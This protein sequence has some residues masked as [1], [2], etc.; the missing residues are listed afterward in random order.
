[1]PFGRRRI[2]AH[3]ADLAVVVPVLDHGVT[4]VDLSRAEALRDLSRT[5]EGMASALHRY[6]HPEAGA[7]DE[8]PSVRTLNFIRSVAA[9]AVYE[10]A[11]HDGDW[12]SAYVDTLPPSH[13]RLVSALATRPSQVLS[14]PR[15]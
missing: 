11:S 5:V 2:A 14:P 3:G 1:V 13:E 7:R 10:I 8:L 9:A 6:A 4:V 15:R 12:V